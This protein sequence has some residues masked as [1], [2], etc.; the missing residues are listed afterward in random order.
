M[1][2]VGTT[3]KLEVN[4]EKACKKVEGRNAYFFPEKI[5]SFSVLIANWPRQKQP[6]QSLSASSEAG[7]TSLKKA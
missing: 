2:H 7:N 1:G 3:R 4:T 6:G 5:L